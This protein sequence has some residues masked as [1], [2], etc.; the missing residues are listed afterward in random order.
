MFMELRRTAFDTPFVSA[1]M[2]ILARGLLVCFQWR[3]AGM[4]PENRKFVLIA[5]P[6]TSNW[7]FFFTLLVAFDL[8]INIYWMGKDTLFR[9]PFNG[10]M[11]WLGG[12]PVDRR[13]SHNLVEQSIE[14][15]RRRDDLTLLVPPSG[16]RSK[17][18]HWKTG[19]YHIAHGAGVPVVLGF[20]DYKHKKGGIGPLLYPSGNLEKDMKTITMF[21]TAITAKY[22]EKA[23]HANACAI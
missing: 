23:R 5:A 11:K 16:T 14:Q 20:L 10:L 13:T 12:I 21:Y 1:I 6:H 17:V 18:V 8:K 19:F 3:S 4:P 2:R 7:D 22:P 15:F 9:K